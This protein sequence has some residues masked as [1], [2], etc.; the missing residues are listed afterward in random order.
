MTLIIR[1]RMTLIIVHAA[2]IIPG[3]QIFLTGKGSRII[4]VRVPT[5]IS[6]HLQFLI[7]L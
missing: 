4:Y 7:D 5:V 2:F 3:R 1:V 6:A